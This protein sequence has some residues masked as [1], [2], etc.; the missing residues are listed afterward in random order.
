MPANFPVCENFCRCFV[1]FAE[2]F[3][4]SS[5]LFTDEA[6]FGREGI[7]NDHNKHQWAEERSSLCNPF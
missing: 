5:V 7:I 6:R 4:V 2:H 1:R 3:F